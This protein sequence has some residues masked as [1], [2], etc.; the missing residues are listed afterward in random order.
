[1]REHPNNL[2]RK[3]RIAGIE[4]RAQ[5]MMPA[6]EVSLPSEVSHMVARRPHLHFTAV[7]RFVDEVLAESSG[8]YP[9]VTGWCGKVE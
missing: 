7:L 4:G 6:T 8:R 1:M 5:A 3:I 2:G 9:S